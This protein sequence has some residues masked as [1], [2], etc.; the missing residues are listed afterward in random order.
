[1]KFKKDLP[2][3][4]LY[5][6]IPFCARKCNYCDF[7]S[8]VSGTKTIDLYL[9]AIE[10]ELSA[11]KGQ[12][13]FKTVFIGGGTPSVLTETQLE[14][15]L[16]TVIR[17]I[18]VSEV[19]EYTVEVNPGTLTVN[20]IRLLKQYGV[21]RISLGVQ[22]FQD[23]QLKFLGRI[24]SG[25]DARKNFILLRQA[26]FKNINIDLMFGCPDQSLDDWENDLE[27]AVELNPEHI[28]TYALTYE[29]G[30]LLTKNL[31]NRIISKLDECIE[32]EMYKTVIDYLTHNGY[33]HYEISNFAK[34][35][36]ECSHNLVYWNNIGYVGVGAGAYSFI[37]GVRTSNE[38]DIIRYINGISEGKNIKSFGEHLP[39]DQFA[40]ETVIMSL[41]LREGISNYDFYRRFGYKLEDQFS[42]QINRLRGNGLISYDNEKLKLTEK[43][44]FIADTVMT[45]FV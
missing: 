18:S 21:N 11:L 6:H 32:L 22:S 19:Q 42:D 26:G 15:L 35:G 34:P 4:A 20:K 16:C 14:K 13:V 29:E 30:T 28:S 38:N 12:Y 37:D 2:P 45:E 9:S 8:V 27:T 33:N 41:R 7:N 23:R 1:M 24:H 31:N 10:S 25:D 3:N 40:S 36:C 17:Y 44:L 5:V 43:G 39:D